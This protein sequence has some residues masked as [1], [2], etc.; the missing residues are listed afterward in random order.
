MIVRIWQDFK[1]WTRPNFKETTEGGVK[2]C[3]SK[4]RPSD[5]RLNPRVF[6]IWSRAKNI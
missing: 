2:E 3:L 1:E 6:S 4:S 5:I